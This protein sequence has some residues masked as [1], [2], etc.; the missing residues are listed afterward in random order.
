MFKVLLAVDPYPDEI[1]AA[2]I[3]GMKLPS[4]S[5]V[6]DFWDLRVERVP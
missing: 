4:L 2:L 3:G 6:V 5:S 1:F